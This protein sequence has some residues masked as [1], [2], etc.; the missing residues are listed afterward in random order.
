M[1]GGVSDKP[2]VRDFSGRSLA[3]S[4]LAIAT[5]ELGVLFVYCPQFLFDAETG[6]FGMD[7]WILH[8]RRL[9]FV[10]AQLAA[11]PWSLPGWYPHELLGTPFWANLQNFPWIPTRLALLGIEPG[12]AYGVGVNLAATLAALFTYLFARSPSIGWGRAAAAL[13][14]WTFACAGFFAARVMVGHLPLLEAYP[15]LPLLLWLGEKATAESPR[16]RS[17]AAL[18]LATA[19]VVVAGHPQLP[20]YAVATAALYLLWVGG[21]RGLQGCMAMGLGA[22]ATLFVWWPMLALLQRSTRILS[23]APAR[24]DIALPYERLTA[25]LLPWRDGWPSAVAKEPSVAFSGYPS[26]AYFWDTFAYVGIAPWVAALAL[27][28]LLVAQRR[29]PAPRMLFFAAL[30]FGSLLFALPFVQQFFALFPGTYLRS[31]SRLLYLT[32]FALSLAVGAAL[33][34]WLRGARPAGAGLRAKLAAVAVGLHVFDLVAHDRPFIKGHPRTLAS[35]PK[36]E[37]VLAK[38]LDS[39]R[40]AF[41]WN[42]AVA[43]NRRFDDAGFFDSIL[44]ARPYTAIFEMGA[45]PAGYNAQSFRAS[46]LPAHALAN[47]GVRFVVTPRKK[48]DL[49]RVLT[50]RYH[51]YAVPAVNPRVAFFPPNR[52]LFISEPEM[53][54]HLSQPD[55]ELRTTLMLEPEHAKPIDP[56]TP[57]TEPVLAYERPH[58]DRIEL[59]VDTQTAGYVRVLESWD[60]GWSATLDDDPTPLFRADTFA[61]ALEIPAGPHLVAL[62]YKTPG[63]RAGAIA[64]ALS[65]ALLA[66][67]LWRNQR[68]G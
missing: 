51:L 58:P 16:S 54:R 47:L 13:A 29:R 4:L 50:E 56:R 32:S 55:F 37:A 49:Q 6:L 43:P 31:A 18:A 19:C 2:G 66:A 53:H 48:N 9:Q 44:L 46:T 10:H 8:L 28:A 42:L 34:T 33:H 23:L 5:M 22:G 64:S 26:S 45:A 14:G 35:M 1:S 21:R 59:R 62:S 24:N 39:G 30:G 20:F 3:A 17:L 25:L 41:D 36:T 52:V 61:M 67:L 65:L 7:Y 11:T 60:P 15:G 63:A 57:D 40:V 68:A 27:L 38:H 12:V